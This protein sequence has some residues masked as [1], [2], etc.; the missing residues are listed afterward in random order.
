MPEEW[1]RR[2]VIEGVPETI[3]ER[4]QELLDAG[5]DGLIFN[6]PD[7]QD[8]EPVAMAGEVLTKIL[9]GGRHRPA[10]SGSTQGR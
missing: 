4:A 1:Y 9:G 10:R 8:L 3:A 5:L 6:M 7:A 2:G